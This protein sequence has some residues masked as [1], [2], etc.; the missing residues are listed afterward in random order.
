MSLAA[1]L[2]DLLAFSVQG[3]FV[4]VVAMVS[5]RALPIERPSLNLAWWQ[6]VLTAAIVL[7][8]LGTFTPAGRDRILINVGALGPTMSPAASA[9]G[10]SL[11]AEWVAA[12]LA[13]GVLAR[14]S[15][16]VRGA[17]RLRGL[18]HRAVPFPAAALRGLE[19][20]IGARA[21][22]WLSRDVSVPATFG[23]RRPI[24]L[25][26]AAVAEMEAERQRA[27]VAH[28]LIHV[29]R[30]DW[31]FA[32]AEE[33]LA[34]V[35]WF[36]PGL[37]LLL[38]RIRLARE[39][40]VDAAVIEAIGGRKAYL[41]ALL[42]AARQRFRA[43]PVPAALFLGE[44]HLSERVEL[45]LKEVAMSKVRAVC[46]LSVSAL[47]LVLA[48]AVGS[49]SFPLSASAEPE[50]E[51]E[52]VVVGKNGVREPRRVSKVDPV[53]PPE[54]KKDHIQG[55]VHID[56]RLGKDGSIA[57]ATATDGHPSLAE[58]ALAAVRQWR[59][60]PVLGPDKKPV[61]AKLTITVNFRLDD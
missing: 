12:F 27:I 55:L 10:R 43:E 35:F 20:A 5:K 42:D 28:E 57:E 37:H 2:Q 9:V 39:Q 51:K 41:E 3:T 21:E 40:Y 46:H 52:A 18:R 61:E 15:Y 48:G 11:G 47:L 44:H 1:F 22:V 7:P 6:A 13:L 34:V 38:G 54:A 19:G 8:F 49:A 58:A 36:H 14:A 30:R 50:K 4:A 17:W 59:Y 32:V 60:E 29:R 26:P 45:L 31:S 53:Y 25:L 24:V 33:V 56:V 16:L 23:L